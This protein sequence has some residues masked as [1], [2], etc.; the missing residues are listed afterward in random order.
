MSEVWE[1]AQESV[2][3]VSSQVILM[4]RLIMDH[5]FE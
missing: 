2:F 3:L 4:L 1:G 5:Y